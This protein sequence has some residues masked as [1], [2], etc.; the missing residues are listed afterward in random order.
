MRM[1]V[2]RGTAEPV[3]VDLVE[4]RRALGVL[5]EPGGVVE[6][7]AIDVLR[8]GRVHK[9]VSGY[10][11]DMDL[12]AGAAAK[13]SGASTGVYVVM[14]PLNPALL[15]RRANRVD[16]A[17]GGETT[18]DQD[19]TRRR[20][21]LVDVD[22]KRPAKISATDAEVAAARDLRD[23]IV[24]ELCSAEGGW[25]TPVLAD[26][27]NGAH[28]LWRIDLPRDDGGLVERTLKGLAQRFDDPLVK[29][30]TSVHNPARITKLYGTL[31]RKGDQ[32]PDRPWRWSR[33][34]ETPSTYT[35][36]AEEL[37]AS[38]AISPQPAT[39][40]TSAPPSAGPSPF[41]IRGFVS[42]H[43]TTLRDWRDY[44]QGGELIE[45]VCPFNPDHGSGEAVIGVKPS[46]ALWFECRHDSCQLRQWSDVRE[47]FEPKP[48]R[49]PTTAGTEPR[50][51]PDAAPTPEP[52]SFAHA[53]MVALSDVQTALGRAKEA[54]ERSPLFS[55]ADDLFLRDYPATPWL[56]DGLIS[57]G[58]VA[59]VG[60][61]PKSGKTWSLAEIAVAIA[62]GTAVWGEF[63]ADRGVVAYFFAEDLAV[64]IRNRLRALLASRSLGPVALGGRLHVCPR[65][66]F[67]DVTRDQDLAWLI[68]SC[69]QIGKVDLLVLDPLRDISSAAEDKSDEMSPVMR[70][71]RLLG[72]LCGA[73]VAVAH[74]AGK[75]T[76]D[77]AKRRP[78]QRMRGSGAIHGATDS[79]I[80]I[81][82]RGGDGIG[83]FDLD[84]DSEIKGA[85]SAG[86]FELELT[87]QDDEKG[88]A[89]HAAWK[90]SRG[91]REERREKPGVQRQRGVELAVAGCL[92]EADQP[93]SRTQLRDALGVGKYAILDAARTLLAD[94]R[95][96]EVKFGKNRGGWPLWTKE[97]AAS[98]G[99]D[100]VPAS[101]SVEVDS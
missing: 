40:T 5:R 27:G 22:A 88:S 55:S 73:T 57:R 79:G 54:A 48:I 35:V 41:D 87:V 7:R 99:V 16:V 74:H 43:L 80:Y 77:T 10:F 91:G 9:V 50:R 86:G 42:R 66:Q 6:I 75:P 24:V 56:V 34:T 67:I 98:A 81:G 8:G 68:A 85:R 1:A 101:M 61:E 4:V 2:I 15:A 58:G 83:R 44:P 52:G 64:Q 30:D 94:G 90:V 72:E 26:S 21:L 95:A 20:W 49:Q 46:G 14:N 53:L 78:G 23:R 82:V 17:G 84:V 3:D 70:R 63:P 29:V 51:P 65:G 45:V 39:R 89:T 59:M 97:R 69:R 18:A 100:V 13:L 60:A 92:A 37:L 11:D 25:P 28:A 71:L 12:A 93:M 19:I 38:V 47:L 36:A 31:A 76:A 33:I 96:V 32:T 62:T